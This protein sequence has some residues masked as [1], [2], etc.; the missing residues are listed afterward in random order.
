MQQLNALGVTGALRAWRALA[1]TLTASALTL[2][3][4]PKPERRT[5]VALPSNAVEP[6]PALA[7]A[8]VAQPERVIVPRDTGNA[9]ADALLAAAQGDE[10]ELRRAALEGIAQIGGDRAREFLARRFAAASDGQ[11]SELASALATLGDAPARAI[12]R[13]AAR[14]PRPAARSAA[15]EALATLDGADVRDF[16]VQAL[17]FMDPLPAAGYFA[18]CREPRA[19]PGLERVARNGDAD[20]RR[21]AIDALFAQGASAEDAISRLVRD[22][23]ELCDAMLE[24]QPPTPA[25]RRALRRASI[26]RLRAGALTSGGVF[27]FLA[28]DLSGEARDALVEAAREP[29]SR[30]SALSALSARGDSGS[31]RALSMLSNDVDPG[32]SQ[33]SACALLSNPDSRWRPYLLRSSRANLPE[34]TAA[35]L[36]RIHAPSGRSI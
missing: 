21:A 16:M 24:G 33:R 22:D 36:E 12:L 2:A 27:D 23:D 19:L 1:L 35:A 29:S 28:R 4:Y 7:V 8:V 17:D 30:D 31:L 6:A 14:S 32:L 10:P 18:D 13:A 5:V 15:F 9:V 25:A 3:L 34:A 20:Q 11:L 26:A